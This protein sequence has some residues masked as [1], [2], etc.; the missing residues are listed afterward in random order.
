VE[1]EKALKQGQE[2]SKAK[3]R[4]GDEKQRKRNMKETYKARKQ[5]R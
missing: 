2:A 5:T 1:A 3:T 4:S